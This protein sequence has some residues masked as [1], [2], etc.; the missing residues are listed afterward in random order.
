M[1]DRKENMYKDAREER[2]EI[3]ENTKQLYKSNKR[4][5]DSIENS[6]KGQ[7][8]IA[9]NDNIVSTAHHIYETSAKIVVSKKRSLEAA[10]SYLDQKVCVLN[11]A[12]ATNPGGGVENGSNAQEEAIC[13]CSTLFPCMSDSKVVNQFHYK[14][15]AELKVGQINVLYND[16]CIYTPNVLIFK[17]DTTY[18]KL[19]LEKDWYIIDVISCAA[20]NLRKKPSNYMNPNGGNMAVSIKASELLNLHMK[21]MRRILDIAKNNKE[22]VVILGAFGCGAF[23]N[24]PDVV[25]EAMARVIKDYIYDFKVIE[26]AIYCSPNDKR[27]YDVFNRRLSR[28]AKK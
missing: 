12:S 19:M 3:F 7:L 17:T 16:D 18:P 23:Q 13:R 25:A 11:F 1:G 24:S 21:R 4:L 15:Q 9:E 8:V 20:P 27:N 6:K 28:I 26:F 10:R 5:I 2:K 14:H 22:E